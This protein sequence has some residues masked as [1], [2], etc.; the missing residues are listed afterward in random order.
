MVAAAPTPMAAP[1]PT[2]APLPG[3]ASLPG[4]AQHL[5]MHSP[6]YAYSDAPALYAPYEPKM[7]T[8]VADIMSRSLESWR[9]IG[10]VDRNTSLNPAPQILVQN[11]TPNHYYRVATCLTNHLDN[12]PNCNPRSFTSEPQHSGLVE[13]RNQTQA[14]SQP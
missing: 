5:P 10:K 13:L 14:M 6:K 4:P 1:A 8:T 12:I 2:T 11:V 9:K 7:M 3:S